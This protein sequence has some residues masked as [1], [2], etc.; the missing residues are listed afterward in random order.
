METGNMGGGTMETAT[1]VHPFERF[2]FGRAPY[3]VVG[4]EVKLFQACPGEPTKP[5]STCD[6]CLTSIARVYWIESTDGV[7]FKVGCDCVRKTND[8]K[9][10]K[11]VSAA[12][13]KVRR[14]KAAKAK[15]AKAVRTAAR[16]SELRAEM[17]ARKAELSARPHPSFEGKSLYDYLEYCGQYGDKQ[18]M[19]AW[20][21]AGL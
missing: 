12:E 11:V 9:L 3:R 7:R 17:T 6:Y 16:A 19:T 13:A 20:K 21:R 2:G 1:L 18:L 8:A 4:T 15:A 14:E 10:I 5:G